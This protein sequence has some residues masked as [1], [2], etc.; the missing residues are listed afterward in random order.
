MMMTAAG[1]SWISGGTCGSL[2]RGWRHQFEDPKNLYQ[3]LESEGYFSVPL[4]KVRW[5]NT[6]SQRFCLAA[7]LALR[8]AY[9]TAE[10]L[11]SN[12]DPTG[13]IS[14][15]RDGALQSNLEYFKDYV[16]SGRKL[17]RGNLFVH[18]LPTSP[19]AETAITFGFKG[20]VL[21]LSASNPKMNLLINRGE[22]LGRRSPL[23]LLCFAADENGIICFFIKPEEKGADVPIFSLLEIQKR[24]GHLWDLK[25]IFTALQIEIEAI[26]K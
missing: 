5:L 22:A 23:N 21:H 26:Q 10:K 11:R 24:I 20:P 12:L 4:A 17:A 1:I 13:V 7:G 19:L 8:D 2:K 3:L 16:D 6:V 15:N 14:L 9:G 18:T 25:E